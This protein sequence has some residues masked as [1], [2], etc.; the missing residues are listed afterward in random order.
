MP[1]REAAKA[2]IDDI[3][4]RLREHIKH[5]VFVPGQRLIE[6]DLVAELGV[7]RGRVREALKILVG[8]GYLEFQENRG[9]L[10]RRMSRAEVEELSRSR[11]MLEGLAA[12]LAAE[13]ATSKDIAKHFRDLQRELDDAVAAGDVRR[14]ARAN[15]TFHDYIIALADNRYVASFLTRLRIPLFRLQFPNALN[16][17][18]MVEGNEDHRHIARAIVARDGDA[19][20]AAMRAH[21]RN[22]SREL[23]ALADA[24]FSSAA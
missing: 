13:R 10:V 14:Y 4:E 24:L 7:G 19:A 23:M 16:N 6:A 9:V 2:T 12:R 15:D 1:R 18:A 20:D 8:E 21:M 17:R 5:G 22:G 3:A 11:E